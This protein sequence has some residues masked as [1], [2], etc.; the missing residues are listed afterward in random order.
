MYRVAGAL[1]VVQTPQTLVG[2]TVLMERVYGKRGSGQ[3]LNLLSRTLLDTGYTGTCQ[4]LVLAITYLTR[5]AQNTWG[6]TKASLGA[7]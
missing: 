2:P 6:R 5:C 7:H 1:C 3:M 4:V